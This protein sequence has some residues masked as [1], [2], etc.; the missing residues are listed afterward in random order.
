MIQYGVRRYGTF[1][2]KEYVR[3]VFTSN[4]TIPVLE[5]Q[6]RAEWRIQ[7]GTLFDQKDQMPSRT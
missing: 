1:Q 3:T 6:E 4:E 2:G 5:I 7:P